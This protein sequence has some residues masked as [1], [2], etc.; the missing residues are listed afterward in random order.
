MTLPTEGLLG[1]A[2]VCLDCA[3][4]AA[5]VGGTC[6]AHAC[7]SAMQS[8]ALS[9]YGLD[10]FVLDDNFPYLRKGKIG[11]PGFEDFLEGQYK[12]YVRMIVRKYGMYGAFPHSVLKELGP[13]FLCQVNQI[14]HGQVA[15]ALKGNPLPRVVVLEFY[16]PLKK[17]TIVSDS[18]W[19]D[20]F[21]SKSHP[22]THARFREAKQKADTYS[23]G[24]VS[25]G[26]H[27]IALVARAELR[28]VEVWV[29]RNSWGRFAGANGYCLISA[30]DPALYSAMQMKFYDVFYTVDAL[31]AFVRGK[32]DATKS[33]EHEA[34]CLRLHSK[35]LEKIRQAH[36]G[37]RFLN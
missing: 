25:E 18:L 4:I 8:V 36:P 21:A 14:S 11:D 7:A 37:I 26:G 15:K 32:F 6:Y 23:G 3:P 9:I 19:R 34:G 5:Q 2:D 20:F 27:A 10:G 22:L 1:A 33:K 16:M 28:G 24:G 13:K 31:P 30:D 12:D 35:M 29:A 17:D